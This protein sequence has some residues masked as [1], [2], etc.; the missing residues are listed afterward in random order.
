MMCFTLQQRADSYARTFPEWPRSWSLVLGDGEDARLLAEWQFGQDYHNESE[1]YGAFPGNYL[2]RLAALFPEHA[3]RPGMLPLG[4]GRVL[5][6]FSGSLA[7]GPYDRCDLN[8]EVEYRCD[9]RDLPSRVSAAYD[10][11]IADPPY[12]DEDAA[13][14]KSP[15]LDRGAMTTAL[16]AVTVTGGF[17]CW[18]DT[19]WPMHRADEWSDVGHVF[20]VRS[21]N[22]RA[23][24][25]TIFQRTGN[26][27]ER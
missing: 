16:A 21:T 25:L 27:H 23:R 2:A 7:P 20:V 9:V 22:H 26:Y 17:L 18:L 10:L 13:K 8:Q 1:Y 15:P 11:I 3:I 4:A 19:A 24:L 14:Y 12:S 6:A 5:H